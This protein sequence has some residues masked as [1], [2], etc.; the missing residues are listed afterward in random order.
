MKIVLV[1][2]IEEPVPPAKYGGTELVVS[3]LAEEMT[4][5]GH[6]VYLLAAG[7]SKTTAHLVP[8]VPVSLRKK[9]SSSEIDTWRSTEKLL[10]ISRV[11]R[12]IKNLKP[13]VVFNHM[14]WRLVPFDEHIE[15]PVYTTIHGP[16]TS[17]SEILTYQQ[18]PGAKLISISDN[19]RLAMPK[20]NWVR[21]IYNGIET[22]LFHQQQSTDR[23]YFAFLGRT[24]PQKGLKEICQM[25]LKTQ[26]RLK[27]AAKVDNEDAQYYESEIKPLIDG[28]QIEFVGEIGP[29]EKTAFL[30]AAKGL[31][32]WLNWEE[33]FGL[34]VAEAMACGTPV[35][36]NRRGAMPE[37]VRNGET[38]YLVNSLDEMQSHLDKVAAINP[39][40]C[41]QYIQDNF[42][43][44]RMAQNYIDLAMKNGE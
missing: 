7:D 44:Q 9:Y 32:L 16:L 37:L 4:S 17:P 11:L 30:H 23:S 21:T 29:A 43:S 25:I 14:G 3:N 12:E 22:S 41:Q 8:L 28:Q 35:I 20:L 5:R 18:Y 2:P 40:T 19:Q 31:L 10:S 24:S 15:C 1:A 34:V 27:I 6:E 38:G 39:K 33:P 42:S 13:D 26:H 36:V